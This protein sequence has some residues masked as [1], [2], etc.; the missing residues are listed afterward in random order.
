M[1][2]AIMVEEEAL[3]VVDSAGVAEEAEAVSAALA[4]VVSAVVV[5][6][7]AGRFSIL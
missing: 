2:V 4:E 1:V 5:R 6:T 3:V 7:E